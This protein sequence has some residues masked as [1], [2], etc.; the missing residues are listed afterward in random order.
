V[1]LILNFIDNIHA[2][3]SVYCDE[4]GGDYYDFIIID[5]ATEQKISV[6]IGDVSGHGIPSALLMATVRSS[7]RQRV[8]LPG[9]TD[10]IISDVNRHLVKADATQII[11][12]VFEALDKFIDGA[13]IEDDITSV[14]IKT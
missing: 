5:D 2:G 3:K 14:V 1:N 13:R 10:K 6:A 7:L 4:T 12:A 8:S 9:S 11:N